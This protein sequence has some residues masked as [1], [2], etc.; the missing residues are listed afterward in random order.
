MTLAAVPTFT[1]KAIESI[2]IVVT[3]SVAAMLITIRTE[4]DRCVPVAHSNGRNIDPDRQIE[5]P[6]TVVILRDP[7]LP[8]PVSSSMALLAE[9]LNRS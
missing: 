3:T 7:W 8:Q 1:R 9:G 6:G 5:M 4:I 2:T